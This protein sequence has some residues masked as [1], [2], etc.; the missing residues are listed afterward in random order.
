MSPADNNAAGEGIS[1]DGRVIVGISEQ[2]LVYPN[3]RASFRW[4][5]ETGMVDMGHLSGSTLGYATGISDNSL[6]VC[7]NETLV[8]TGLSM[9]Y[10]WS[11]TVGFQALGDLAG[12][13][14]SSGAQAISGDGSTIV[15]FSSVANGHQAFRWTATSGMV[16]LPAPNNGEVPANAFDVSYDGSVVV[17]NAS[18]A[19]KLHAYRWT[20]LGG[21]EDL[22]VGSGFTTSSA[23]AV[24]ADGEIIAVNQSPGGIR[25]GYLWTGSGGYR[26]VSQVLQDHFVDTTGWS[27]FTDLVDISADGQTLLGTGTYMGQ[28]SV[29]VA[30]LVP[31]PT[32]LVPF[33][34]M[35]GL[36]TL[37][38]GAR[39]SRSN[40]TQ[41]LIRDLA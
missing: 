5:R 25:K 35:A 39:R 41:K 29:Y 3:T 38:K 24:S 32:Y 12:G 18:V 8:S 20:E 2:S 40:E 28:S 15:G 36:L 7:G 1:A 31:E 14:I 9:G 33:G 10:I 6:I 17:G 26:S 23:V 4:T 21:T 22:G 11:N 13:S 30:Q 16:G 37:R 34:V 27:S 19:G